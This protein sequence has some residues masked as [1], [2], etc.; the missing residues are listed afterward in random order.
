MQPIRSIMIKTIDRLIQFIQHAGMSAR[1]FDISIGASNGYTLRMKK[2]HASIGSDVIE[3]IIKTYPDLNV[4]WLLTGDGT[5]LKSQE[6]SEEL[7]FDKLSPQRQQAIERIIEDKIREKQR[8]DLKILLTEVAK[9][10][11]GD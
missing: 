1:Q 8:N 5:M 3:S 10:I 4:V 9:E 11:N 6:Q 2:N 7:D